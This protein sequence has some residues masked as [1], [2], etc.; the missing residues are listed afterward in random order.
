MKNLTKIH[1]ITSTDPLLSE[2]IALGKKNAKT[3]GM[4]PEGAFI[5]HAKKRNIFVAVENGKIVGYLLFRVT[6]SKGI[7]SIAHLCVDPAFRKR[8]IAKA[9]L[10]ELKKKYKNLLKGIMLSCRKDYIEASRFYEKNEFKAIKEIRSRSQEENFLV[11]WYYDFGNIDLFSDTQF[12][13]EKIN[14]LLDANIIIKLREHESFENIETHALNADWLQD[15]ISFFFAPETY[16]E[17][18]RDTDRERASVTRQF[19]M[20]FQ[21]V[22]F[23]PAIRD[24]VFEELAKFLKGSSPNHISDR[25]QVAECIAFGLS[26]FI[27]NDQQILDAAEEI[28][29]K[30]NLRILRPSEL[31][32]FIDEL[33]NKSDYLSVRLSGA[34]YEYK[35]IGQEDVNLII[36]EFIDNN[37]K[38]HEL[39]NILA[40]V[41]SDVKN[42]EVRLVKDSENNILG[43]FAAYLQN[44]Y[45]KVPAIKIQRNKLSE[46]LFYR[47]LHDIIQLAISKKTSVI[48]IEEVVLNDIMITALQSFGFQERDSIWYK[49]ALVGQHDS[50][51]FFNTNSLIS[52]HWNTQVIIKKLKSLSGNEKEEYKLGLERKL[53]PLKFEDVEIPTYIIPIRSFWA[54]NLF[55]YYQ[56]SHDLFG[57]KAEIAWHRENI[58]FRS[59]RPVSEKIPARI[60]W[61]TSTDSNN[62]IGRDK[63]IVACSY[64]D[65]VHIDEAKALYQKFKNYG[66]YDWE[67]IYKSA[68]EDPKK[69]MKALKFS[70]TEVFCNPISLEQISELMK[71]NG[72]AANTFASPVLITKEIFNQIYKIGKEL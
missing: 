66:V 25:K 28:F 48:H 36:E 7:I 3:L 61:Y 53:W 9:L 19:L 40:K 15:E 30:Y 20:N 51:L 50:E 24:S 27:T 69:L 34:N 41:A 52:N 21:E 42:S 67:D 11:K 26:Y 68:G 65:E 70:D 12:S 35:K 56:A 10:D 29:I 55:D 71:Q 58:Y 47:L 39:R 23:D 32:L 14:V 8:G 49:L 38:K 33:K 4:F 1:I 44:N 59:V 54:A 64:L 57:A 63:G 46:I 22:K 2:V 31:I 17:I 16:N 60:L 45:L 62:P 5:D 13:S 37:I 43:F 18:N 72:K 6:Q